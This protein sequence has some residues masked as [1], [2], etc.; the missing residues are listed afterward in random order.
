MALIV[1]TLFGKKLDMSFFHEQTIAFV[2]LVMRVLLDTG[3]LTPLHS[4]P[5]SRIKY[6]LC[7]ELSVLLRRLFRRFAV[8]PWRS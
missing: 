8:E 4:E 7:N 2:K 6:N 5:E 1:S 3:S